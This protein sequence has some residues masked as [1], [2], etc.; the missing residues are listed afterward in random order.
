MLCIPRIM[1]SIIVSI[2]LVWYTSYQSPHVY[3]FDWLT[4]FH[5]TVLSANMP[6]HSTTIFTLAHLLPLSLAHLPHKKHNLKLAMLNDKTLLTHTL[7]LF[8]RKQS[9]LCWRIGHWRHHCRHGNL[10]IL[11]EFIP[12]SIAKFI[13]P[14]WGPP[15]SCPPQMGPM[16]ATWTLLSGS[17]SVMPGPRPLNRRGVCGEC[18][19]YQYLK[20]LRKLY[21]DSKVHGTNMRP[22][23][24]LSAP[25]G[26][27]ENCYL[28]RNQSSGLLHPLLLR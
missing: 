6:F 24:V 26:S 14:T 27:H 8:W 18:P 11:G 16:L 12:P 17:V 21:P 3:V 1:C 19:R 20:Y 25:C 15:G 4:T 10:C 7:A 22:T 9:C 23:W 2:S 13:G 28:S 5:T